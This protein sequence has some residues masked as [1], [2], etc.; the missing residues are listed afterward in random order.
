MGSILEHPIDFDV[1]YIVCYRLR[2][3]DEEWTR[4]NGRVSEPF[5]RGSKILREFYPDD[6][7]RSSF[8][9]D[10]IPYTVRR[11]TLWARLLDVD[12]ACV[13]DNFLKQAYAKREAATNMAEK[14]FDQIRY[15]TAQ[16]ILAEK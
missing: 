15:L 12:E 10:S 3:D 1:G 8:F 16:R 2:D 6:L 9:V 5:K 14:L 11:G 4:L 13:A 7:S